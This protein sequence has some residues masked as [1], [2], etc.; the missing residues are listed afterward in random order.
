MTYTEF[1]NY[2]GN[3]CS[4]FLD[5]LISVSNNLIHNYIFITIFGLS[6]FVALFWWFYDNFVVAPLKVKDNVDNWIDLKRRYKQFNDMKLNYIS[7]NRIDVELLNYSNLVINRELYLKFL[8]E[9][10]DLAYSLTY[11][12]LSLKREAS[13][14][15]IEQD[16]MSSRIFRHWDSVNKERI[17]NQQEIDETNEILA[18][19]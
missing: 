6:L 16:N 3:G 9:R 14:Q 4:L 15:L 13:K 7:T 18:N 17:V 2:I 10:N 5:T 11:T 8:H 12:S 19:F 1:L